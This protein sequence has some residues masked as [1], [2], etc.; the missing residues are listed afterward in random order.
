[1]RLL[2]LLWSARSAAACD[3]WAQVTW[4]WTR[5]CPLDMI[6]NESRVWS[7]R[8]AEVAREYG[9]HPP[10]SSD[11]DE[12]FEPK[13]TLFCRR[14]RFVAIYALF[15]DLWAKKVPFW[16]KNSVSW[17]RSALKVLKSWKQII[18]LSNSS[19]RD[20]KGRGYLRLQQACRGSLEAAPKK[21]RFSFPQ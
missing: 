6:N 9:W 12:N 10:K 17:K 15:G 8:T 18:V 1:M 21:I 19:S 7:D 13:H 20:S 2:L 16:V 5:N 14:F 3:L 11:S 4:I